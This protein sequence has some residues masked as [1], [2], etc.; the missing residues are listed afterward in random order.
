M[1]AAIENFLLMLNAQGYASMWRTGAWAESALFKQKI[2]LKAEDE[3]AG[4][5]YIGTAARE[6]P[7]RERLSVQGFLVDWPGN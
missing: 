3:I 4:F 7:L 5:I 1:G 6:L 2:G